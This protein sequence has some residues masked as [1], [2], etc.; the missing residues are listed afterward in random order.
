MSTEK[1]ADI[2]VQVPEVTQ[3]EQGQ[4]QKLQIILSVL[5]RLLQLQWNQVRWSVDSK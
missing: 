3:S 2:R 4:K 1:L 5:N